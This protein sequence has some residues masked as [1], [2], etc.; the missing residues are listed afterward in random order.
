[1]FVFVGKNITQ[2]ND[3]LVKMSVEQLINKIQNPKLEFQNAIKQLRIANSIDPN[4]YNEL[5]RTLPYFTCGVFFPLF[6]KKENF[7]TI[8]NFV[9]DL[10]HLSKNELNIDLLSSQLK[11]DDTVLA[12][13]VSPGG[14]GLK[15]LF[16]LKYNC[17][18]AALFSAFYKIFAMK[19]AQKY[20]L[21][22][23]IDLKTSDVSRACFISW[24][25]NAYLKLDAH[26]IDINDYLTPSDFDISEKEI[27]EAN[28]FAKEIQSVEKKPSQELTDNILDKIKQKLNPTFKIRR[29]KNIFVPA[30]ID[31]LMPL[32]E[33]NLNDLDIILAST[34]PLNYG[35]KL[36]V[37]AGIYWAELN[38]FYG[39][40]GYTL[41][42]TPK[43]GSNAQ[44][45][46]MAYQSIYELI[47]G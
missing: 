41:V 25:P 39:K 16:H 29:E 37:K 35:K 36:K 13:F 27:K 7:A 18:D 21:Q 33:R 31:E 38:L 12:F 2:A 24:D 11:Y 30:E 9:I 46:D 8:S 26:S 43:N 42:K 5:K 47:N 40:K 6:R 28:D 15:V 17:S 3:L 34:T 20:S 23:V 1:M 14:D 10:D 45:A 32:L 19:F 22:N 4:K 44:L